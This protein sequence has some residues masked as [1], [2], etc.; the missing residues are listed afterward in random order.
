[1]FRNRARAFATTLCLG[2]ALIVAAGCGGGYGGDYYYEGD[3]EV[4]NLT[5]F[6]V[7]YYFDLVPAGAP[8]GGDLLYEDVFPGEVQ[9]VGTFL[10]D[11]YDGEAFLDTFP[12]TSVW[13]P[14]TFI[15]GDTITTF[16]VF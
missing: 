4:A 12:E 15:E 6:D 8:P 3:V 9:Y 1:M 11:Y 16:E 13:F 5:A 7:I 2:A 14:D 10:E